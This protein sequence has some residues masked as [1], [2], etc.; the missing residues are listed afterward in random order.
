[1]RATAQRAFAYNDALFSHSADRRTADRRAVH[2]MNMNHEI[3]C[4]AFRDVD[5]DFPFA[6]RNGVH[7]P[8]NSAE[9]SRTSRDYN[10]I[11]TAKPMPGRG[12][13]QVADVAV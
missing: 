8:T 7:P 12:F 3:A 1:M 2:G 4:K 11:S 6:V 13:L 9:A 5:G 10:R